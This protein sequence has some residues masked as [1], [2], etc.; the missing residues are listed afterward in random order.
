MMRWSAR[1]AAA[2]ALACLSSA[3]AAAELELCLAE[4]AD[5]S[6]VYS[7]TS[8]PVGA[9]EEVAAVVRL[10]RSHP[11]RTLVATWT[12]VQAGN[13]PPNQVINKVTIPI[14]RKDRA[15]IH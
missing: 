11:Y 4:A 7:T 12:A 8:F 10:D 3:A 6:P 1:L 9:T 15:A 14:Q 13:A 2:I 5:Y